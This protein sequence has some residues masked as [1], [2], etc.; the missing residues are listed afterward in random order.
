MVVVGPLGMGTVALRRLVDGTTL[1]FTVALFAHVVDP[2]ILLQAAWVI[3]GIGA[4]IYRFFAAVL[5]IVIVGAAGLA[6][7]LVFPVAEQSTEREVVEAA[8]I[9]EWPLMIGI[10]VIVAFL[11]DRI[12]T[13]ARHYAAL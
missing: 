12:A 7:T 9:A 4:V 1:G 3:A 13:S 8:D 6:Y 2:E 11:A 10:A 5:R